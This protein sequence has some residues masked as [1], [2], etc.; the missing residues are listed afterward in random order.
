MI[1]QQRL[2]HAIV[3]LAAATALVST[4]AASYAEEEDAYEEVEVTDGGSLSGRVYF[5]SDY[6]EA[7]TIRPTRDGD[8]CGIRIPSEEFV[9]DPDNRGLAGA[10]VQVI[11]VTEGKP[12][13]KVKP[14]LTQ[15]K[16]RYEPH[17]QVVRP[18]TRVKITNQD[19]IL[20][21]VH[22][23][24]G[25]KTLFNIAQPIQGQ[26]TPLKLKKAG[27]VRFACDVHNW[28]D[29]WVLVVDNPYFAVTD[30]AGRFSIDDLPPGDYEITMW[31][32]VLGTSTK[33]ASIAKN[34]TAELDFVI[35]S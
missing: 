11:G 33:S 15:L 20:H 10:I 13:A 19:A 18:G 34:G 7:E 28:M 9:V 35:G 29:A 32:E 1:D 27:M 12:F 4:P 3:G 25:D 2:L 21:N 23:Y 5:D 22:A 14:Q 31:H 8:T 26:V 17:V 24:D 16:C 6:P 30:A